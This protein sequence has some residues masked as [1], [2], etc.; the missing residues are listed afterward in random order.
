MGSEVRFLIGTKTI[1]SNI[2]KKGQQRYL[3]EELTFEIN[4]VQ[5]SLE[6][7]KRSKQKVTSA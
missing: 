4:T 1:F 7:G 5:C 2:C 3:N 6:A